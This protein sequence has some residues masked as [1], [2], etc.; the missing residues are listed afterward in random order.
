MAA[1]S[2]IY[3]YAKAMGMSTSG[4]SIC[5]WSSTTASFYITLV[6][7]N[8]TPNETH[9]YAS[10]FS[11]AELGSAGG[12]FT[13]GCGGTIR[14]SLTGRILNIN[15]TSHQVEFQA[16]T[17]TWSG[18]S[19]GTAHAFIVFHYATSGATQGSDASAVLICYN[20]LGGFPI[21]TNGTNLTL[22]VTSAGLFAGVDF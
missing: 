9:V 14:I 6:S 18:I 12:S 11:G 22:S 4:P 2:F 16:N 20:S 15:T 10:A 13:P 5:Y 17:I 19:T 7:N 1:S 8:Y 21:T 3:D